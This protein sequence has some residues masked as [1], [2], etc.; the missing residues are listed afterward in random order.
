MINKKVQE[1]RVNLLMKRKVAWIMLLIGGSLLTLNAWSNQ[2]ISFT[3]DLN[4]NLDIYIMDINR[5]DPVNLTNHPANDSSPT[6]APDGGAFAY[7]SHRDGNP[8]IYVMDIRSKESRRLTKNG[9]TDI[10][11]AWSPDGRWIAFASNQHREHAADT[12]IYIMNPNGKKGKQLTNKGG[13]NSTPAWS[14]DG[15]WIAFRSTLDGIGGIHLMN[16]DG[17][18]QHPLIQVSATSPTWST[19]GKTVYFSS[20]MLGDVKVP[21]LFAIDV[22]GGKTRKLVNAPHACEEPVESPDGR[23]IAYVSIEGDNKDLYLISVVDGHI[24]QLTQD[25]GQEFSPVW[26]PSGLS[27]SPSAH[28]RVTLWGILK[29]T[30]VKTGLQSAR[31]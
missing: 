21:T 12:D 3:A 24:Q 16:A 26:A 19:D 13:H 29:R 4:G 5:K 10:D 31:H 7:V 25:P 6:W 30:M 8:E 1:D 23:W 27:V 17:K 15:E 28:T 9:A 11:P 20:D 2:T 18:K 22:N 14:P